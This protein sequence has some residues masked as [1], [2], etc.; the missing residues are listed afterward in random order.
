[1]ERKKFTFWCIAVLFGILLFT[2]APGDVNA[3]G[4][5]NNKAKVAKKETGPPPWA[6]AHGYRAKTRYVYFNEYNVYYDHDRGVYISLS[7]NN[8]QVTA[9]LPSIL[10]S[11]DLNAAVKIDLD[12]SGDD[13]QKYNKDH[14]SK[15]GKR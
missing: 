10:S 11:V 2:A 12:F 1:M 6:P 14:R 3:Q 13:P 9:K 15:F 5:G 4:K 8:W 7:G